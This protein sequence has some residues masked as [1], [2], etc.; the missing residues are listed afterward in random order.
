[1]A[2]PVLRG[3]RDLRSMHT[4]TRRSGPTEGPMAYVD[5]LRLMTEKTRLEREL[6][7]WQANVQRIQA[8]LTDIETQM[9]QL[10]E[11][12]AR[13]RAKRS[14]SATPEDTVQEMTLTY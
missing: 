1:V 12:T 13:D 10:D 14:D 2:R 9:Q 6:T 5:M 11:I 7:M 3:M 4:V 8:R